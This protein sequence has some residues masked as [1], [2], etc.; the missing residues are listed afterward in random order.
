[1]MLA[2]VEYVP[3]EK[4]Q[5][6]TTEY[7]L[8]YREWILFLCDVT[9]YTSPS[10]EIGAQSVIEVTVSIKETE[11]MEKEKEKATAIKNQLLESVPAYIVA[12]MYV[13]DGYDHTNCQLLTLL[14]DVQTV[15]Y[16][17]GQKIK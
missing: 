12:N 14:T 3:T 5:A 13:P 8:E 4:Y 7:T 1:M 2:G 6:G 11:T 15:V 9:N 16:E 17:N 10:N